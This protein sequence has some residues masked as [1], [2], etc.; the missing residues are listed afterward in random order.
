[1]SQKTKSRLSWIAA[2]AAI[3]VLGIGGGFGFSQ[4]LYFLLTR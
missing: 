3:S 2:G 1:M 4:A